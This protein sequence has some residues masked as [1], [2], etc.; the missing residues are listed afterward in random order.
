MAI[1]LHLLCYSLSCFKALLIQSLAQLS[2]FVGFPFYRFLLCKVTHCWNVLREQYLCVRAK[3]TQTR[4]VKFVCQCN[5]L[6]APSHISW[7]VNNQASFVWV[8][9]LLWFLAQCKSIQAK[10]ILTVW[11]HNSTWDY[12]YRMP[13]KLFHKIRLSTRYSLLGTMFRPASIRFHQ[14]ILTTMMKP[15]GCWVKY[16]TW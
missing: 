7:L 2:L 13:T 6:P 3:W 5:Q 12:C 4:C 1:C 11:F 8:K 16:C 9:S 10:V 15:S 14:V